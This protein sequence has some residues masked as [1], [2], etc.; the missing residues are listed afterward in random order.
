[1]T[2]LDGLDHVRGH[3]HTPGGS[4]ISNGVFA[5]IVRLWKVFNFVVC[6]W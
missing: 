1:M 2:V 4:I 5:L 3:G 6:S